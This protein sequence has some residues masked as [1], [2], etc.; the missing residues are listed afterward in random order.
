MIVYSESTSDDVQATLNGEKVEIKPT[1]TQIRPA[2][3]WF[4]G[5]GI[6]DSMDLIG[7]VSNGKNH[8]ECKTTVKLYDQACEDAMVQKPYA[9]SDMVVVYNF[10]ARCAL[11]FS[12]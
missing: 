4:K 10:R 7:K 5:A 12:H 11:P 6:G 8:A 9:Y 1:G 3:A 2:L